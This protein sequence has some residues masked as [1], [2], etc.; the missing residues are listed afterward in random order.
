MTKREQILKCVEDKFESM[1]E[2]EI[3]EY[4][5]YLGSEFDE[6]LDDD[7]LEES[8]YESSDNDEISLLTTEEY[9]KYKWII[10]RIKCNWWLRS[11]G[12]DNFWKFAFATI[13]D[14]EGDICEAGMNPTWDNVG[15]RPALRNITGEYTLG[16]RIFQYD[17]PWIYLR[18]GIAIAETP[19]FFER[20]DNNDQSINYD[21]S[22]VR[23]RLIKWK[24][25]R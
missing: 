17:F 6:D 7:D 24:N 22:Y 25:T 16:E 23:K 8:L 15:V 9:R 19:I 1:T 2:Y 10:P 21:R 13:V 5:E 14:P 3:E 12:F 11:P 4:L 18:D 20:F